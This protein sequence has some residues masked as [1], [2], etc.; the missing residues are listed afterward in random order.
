MPETRCLFL[1]E[2][3]GAVDV[4][5]IGGQGEGHGED[6]TGTWAALHPDLAPQVFGDLAR[7]GEPQPS[8]VGAGGALGA[9]EAFE[10]V[11]YLG[12]GDAAAAVGDA[13]DRVAVLAGEAEVHGVA[14]V[15]VLQGVVQEDGEHAVQL[16]RIRH[17]RRDALVGVDAH[18][19][20]RVAEVPAQR[21]QEVLQVHLLGA[22]G[23]GVRVE[24]AKV[25][26]GAGEAL[27]A[28]GLGAHVLEEL[29]PDPFV[30]LVLEH[31]QVARE[32]GQGRLQL[33]GGVR[34]ELGL[35]ALHPALLRHVAQDGQGAVLEGGGPDLDDPVPH[36]GLG[37]GNGPGVASLGEDLLQPDLE[38]QVRGLEQ[39]AGARVQEDGVQVL[40]HADHRVGHTVEDRAAPL[41]LVLYL[42][43]GA[44]EG[45][46]HRVEG[47]AERAHLVLDAGLYPL[48]EVAGGQPLGGYPEAAD[49]ARD[50]G[51]RDVASEP[52][53]AQRQGAREKGYA[54]YAVQR[55]LHV[56]D[57]ALGED[58]A[59]D[60]GRPLLA[61]HLRRVH[62]DG[63]GGQDL[64]LARA[65]LDLLELHPRGLA[66]YR[67]LHHAPVPLAEVPVSKELLAVPR[68]DYPPLQAPGDGE[69]LQLRHVGL[70]VAA[71]QVLELLG[72]RLEAGLARPVE[73]ILEDGTHDLVGHDRGEGGHQHEQGGEPDAHAHPR[74]LEPRVQAAPG[75]G[76]GGG[77]RL[78]SEEPL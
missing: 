65:G 17:D 56:L 77:A 29:R 58:L 19:A 30:F 50:Q 20:A 51:S 47:G 24:A 71:E 11:R 60:H 74:F 42:L 72:N 75:L 64:A 25:E 48:V 3:G 4:P 23:G 6:A 52:R 18:R 31:L 34:Y 14:F 59:E 10:D 78:L 16:G 13:D 21:V 54:L 7:Q 43:E 35:R 28:L 67:V 55:L 62:R 61:R 66:L 22:E 33:V 53:E 27:E 70:A 38:V 5:R 26:Q 69:G 41:L 63:V 40:V 73:G 37:L 15:R 44:L 8:A 76:P 1:G 49:A 2:A 57:V 39:L 68:L 9:V 46:S 12:L 45:G 36:L 32:R